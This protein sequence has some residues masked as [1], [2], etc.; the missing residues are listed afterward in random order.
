MVIKKWLL[1]LSLVESGKTG[2][3]S[4]KTDNSSYS[5][6]FTPPTRIHTFGTGRYMVKLALLG[7]G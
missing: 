7:P 1:D 4:G 6:I 5:P 2:N 3:S